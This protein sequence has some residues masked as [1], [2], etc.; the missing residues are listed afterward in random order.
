MGILF[1]EVELLPKFEYPVA[2]NDIKVTMDTKHVMSCGVYKPSIKIHNL[3]KQSII[4]ERN[5]QNE[6]IEVVPIDDIFKYGILTAGNK[7]EL[8][9]QT[10]MRCIAKVALNSR[11]AVSMKDKLVV[12]G[13]RRSLPRYDLHTNKFVDALDS[14]L[15]EVF[16]MKVAKPCTLAVCGTAAVHFLDTDSKKISASF[17]FN[18]PLKSMDIAGDTCYV[19]DE[20][21]NIHAVDLR[22]Q[23]TRHKAASE[24]PVDLLKASN[25]FLV[26][27]G[28]GHLSLWKAQALVG[29]VGLDSAINAIEVAGALVFVGLESRKMRVFYV[30]EMGDPP[31]W[32]SFVRESP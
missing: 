4:L 32:C 18:S 23:K 29:K 31:A 13:D 25:D 28:G 2:C 5:I 1:K 24:T 6:P 7:L 17:K 8:H 11:T 3:P 30:S 10:G 20:D 12:G 14:G 19:G 22:T 9:N 16:K 27:G 26:S 15:D 21:G